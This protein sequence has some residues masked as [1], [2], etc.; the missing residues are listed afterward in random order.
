MYDKITLKKYIK[1]TLIKIYSLPLLPPLSF[2][3]FLIF[4][5]KIIFFTYVHKMVFSRIGIRRR[6]WRIRGRERGSVH[7]LGYQLVC[8][9]GV[10]FCF[11]F[12]QIDD[13]IVRS[14]M[15]CGLPTHT[16]V[17]MLT[18]FMYAKKFRFIDL[19]FEDFAL[20][21]MYIRYRLKLGSMSLHFSQFL[22]LLFLCYDCYFDYYY[23][24]YNYS[25]NHNWYF[26]L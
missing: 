12:W 13:C 7:S 16:Y 23:N 9:C 19:F 10:T 21:A 11:W 24:S 2:F 5:K 6:N 4:I 18:C 25:Y 3:Y 15:D 14:G 22:L 17:H 20:C 26:F 8:L 1:I